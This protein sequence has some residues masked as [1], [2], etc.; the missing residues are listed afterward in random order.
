VV[1]ST[2][3]VRANTTPDVTV[4]VSVEELLL[5]FGSVTPAGRLS[6]AVLA[7]DVPL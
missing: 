7:M 3:L 1:L 5:V 2:V 4:S 6:A